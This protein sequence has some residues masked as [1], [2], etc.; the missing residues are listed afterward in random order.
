MDARR[1]ALQIAPFG[2]AA[3]RRTV[4]EAPRRCYAR[5]FGDLEQGAPN[6]VEHLVELTA[7]GSVGRG[8][9]SAQGGAQRDHVPHLVRGR[10]A[11]ELTDDAFVVAVPNDFTRE[12][13]EGHFLGLIQAAV[14]DATGRGA[15]RSHHRR[16]SRRPEARRRR[17]RGASGR[18]RRRDSG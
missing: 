15:P 9:R 7:E 18:P 17:C 11:V 2:P 8:L 13:I 16:R 10:E 12:W 1:K 14:R 4:V 6:G 5:R 3:T